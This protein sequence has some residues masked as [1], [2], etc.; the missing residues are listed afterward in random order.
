MNFEKNCDKKQ[1]LEKFNLSSYIDYV[2]QTKDDEMD[3]VIDEIMNLFTGDFEK[4]FN[5]ATHILTSISEELNTINSYEPALIERTFEVG[6]KI[7]YKIA[8]KL[9]LTDYFNLIDLYNEL[10]NS[11]H[12]LIEAHK[13]SSQ[14]MFTNDLH[15][16]PI[17]DHKSVEKLN[18]ES[19]DDELK[20]NELIETPN[21]AKQDSFNGPDWLDKSDWDSEKILDDLECDKPLYFSLIYNNEIKGNYSGTT[22]INAA[23]KG[24]T[25]LYNSLR[26]NEDSAI[27]SE[28]KFSLK[29]IT[30]NSDNEKFDYVGERVNLPL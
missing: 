21:P 5:I 24:F 7:S 27:N 22:P 26:K 13:N 19:I 3:S 15:N 28:I 18:S 6:S 1:I 14:K 12:P 30:T 11:K 2:N 8:S 20:E 9:H 29:E 10:I 4:N 16:S 17:D 23:Y 25:C